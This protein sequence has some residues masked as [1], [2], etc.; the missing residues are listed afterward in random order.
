MRT[1]QLVI[2]VLLLAFLGLVRRNLRDYY[3]RRG[4]QINA[5]LRLHPQVEA[6]FAWRG[7]RQEP[8]RDASGFSVWNGDD[9]FRPNL[10]ARDGRPRSPPP[11]LTYR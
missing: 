4:V 1:Y 7:E 8:L 3:R 5:A 10:S 9:A 11:D 2:T 6:L